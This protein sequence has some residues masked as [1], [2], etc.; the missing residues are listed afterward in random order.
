MLAAMKRIALVV[1][2]VFAACSGGPTKQ[3]ASRLFGAA[4]VALSSAQSSAVSAGGSHGLVAPAQLSLDYSGPCALGGTA[5]VS[6]TYDDTSGS[7]SDTAFDMT[8]SF[9]AC[10]GVGGTLDGSVHWTSTASST[11]FSAT[12]NGNLDWTDGN[13]SAS[14]GID[15]QL[16]VTETSVSYS[17][18]VCG[19]DVKTD[20]RM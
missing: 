7:G 20:L 6:G 11:G 10:H 5:A 19:Y 9:A 12:M 13:D 17:G 18:S 4:G 1:P 8:V 15:V 14:C 3:E 2:F 16:A